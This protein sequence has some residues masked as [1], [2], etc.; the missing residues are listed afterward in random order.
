MNWSVSDMAGLGSYSFV[1]DLH[2]EHH[3]Q[4]TASEAPR[5]KV[6][7]WQAGIARHNCRVH[8]PP[9]FRLLQPNSN[10]TCACRGA[11]PITHTCR[12]SSLVPLSAARIEFIMCNYVLLRTAHFLTDCRN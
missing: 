4:P 2:H 8:Y 7:A 5:G 11:E 3:A 12:E 1:H 10:S 9:R 6:I